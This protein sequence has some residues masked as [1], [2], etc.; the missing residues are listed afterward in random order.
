M[1]RAVIGISG[2]A[3]RLVADG[4][5][6]LR[7]V[8]EK[9]RGGFLVVGGPMTRV[10]LHLRPIGIPPRATADVDLGIDRLALRLVGNRRLIAPL[11]RETGF[12]P[13]PGDE[14]FRFVKEIEGR[15]LP[16]DFGIAPGRSRK[17][18]PLPGRGIATIAIPGPT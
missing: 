10:W 13:R 17:E 15:A 18:P 6:E 12:E 1:R 5:E 7:P 2:E 16:V 3:D 4:L 14:R 9:L 11:L 8:F